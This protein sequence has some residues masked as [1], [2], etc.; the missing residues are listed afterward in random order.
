M[1][2]FTRARRAG[3]AVVLAALLASLTGSAS[4][5]SAEESEAERSFRL[6]QEH[7]VRGQIQEACALFELSLKKEEATGTLVN[8]AFCHEKEGRPERAW[9]EFK[10]A[11]GKAQGERREFV[12]EH[13]AALEKK[14]GHARIDAGSHSISEVK[15]DGELAT[16][17]DK[18][19]IAAAPG[20]HTVVVSIDGNKQSATKTMVR[21]RL[22]D[23]NPE[24]R[25]TFEGEAPAPESPTVHEAPPREPDEGATPGMNGQRALGIGTAAVGAVSLGLATAF[26]VASLA[27]K[28]EARDDERYNPSFVGQRRGH[29]WDQANIATVLDIVG[30]VALVTGIVLIATS[31]APPTRSSGRA[32][33][34][35]LAAAGGGGLSLLGAW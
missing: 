27:L 8:L 6:G 4:A 19:R 25:V 2:P 5:A 30:G 12:R 21:F 1:P 10:R 11:E 3:T 15:V 33:V 18:R 20:Y 31:G 28:K 14:I 22:G 9:N 16:L 26:Y 29:A 32:R 13:L 24:I 34:V 7:L 35:P 23:H 17:D